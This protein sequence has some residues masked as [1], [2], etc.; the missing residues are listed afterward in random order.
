MLLRCVDSLIRTK[1]THAD[2]GLFR[3]EPVIYQMAI[4]GSRASWK[5]VE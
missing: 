1:P 3:I 2:E 4:D 5:P